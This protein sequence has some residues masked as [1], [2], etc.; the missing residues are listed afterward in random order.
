MI[1]AKAS[2][3]RRTNRWATLVESLMERRK[4]IWLVAGGITLA[5]AAGTSLVALPNAILFFL[6][7]RAKRVI[8]EPASV[9]RVGAPSDFP[10]GVDTRF[11]QSHRV[12]V[13]RNTDRLY[14]IHA[15]CPHMGCTPDWVPAQNQFRCPCHASAF[16]MGSAF[17]GNGI[18]CAGP[19]PRPLDRVRVE[20]D[21]DGNVVA[22]LSTLYQWPRGQPSQFENA[23][24]YVPLT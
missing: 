14:L 1:P 11:L 20:V 15:R 19:A 13:V 24:A 6:R 17:D 18:N 8:E 23:G 5:V 3:A 12:C 9:F 2:R 4:V 21:A 22:D 16:C 10:I 7:R